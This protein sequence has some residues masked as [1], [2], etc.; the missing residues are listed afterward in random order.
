MSPKKRRKGKGP[1][2]RSGN[3]TK[4]YPLTPGRNPWERQKRETGPAWEAFTVYRTMGATRTLIAVSRELGKHETLIQRWGKVWRWNE[5]VDLWD[6]EQMA[7]LEDDAA[8]SLAEMKARHR[9][10]A[11]ALQGIGLAKFAAFVDKQGEILTDK[12]A[13]VSITEARRLVDV[14][15]RMERQTYGEKLDD[16][17]EGEVESLMDL[18]AAEDEERTAKAGV[19]GD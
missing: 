15:V 17:A 7:R 9:E 8:D 6:R 18:V 5:R 19:G 16:D 13:E 4:P 3:R 10:Q 14:G 1:I 11:K 12:L 2:P